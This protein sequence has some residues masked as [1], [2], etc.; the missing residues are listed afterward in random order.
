MLTAA[1]SSLPAEAASYAPAWVRRRL[2]EGVQA[3]A[4]G[5]H[6]ELTGAVLF[7]DV[8]GFTPLAE[9]SRLLNDYFGLLLAVVAEHGGEPFKFAGDALMALWPAAAADLATAT[10]RAAACALAIQTRLRHFETPGSATLSLRVAVGQGSGSGMQL[11]ANGRWF[12]VVGGP[13]LSDALRALS[14]AHAREAVVS[15]DA[16]NAISA[17]PANLKG[18]PPCSATTASSKPK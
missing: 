18:S 7:A 16:W 15:A 1:E 4:A 9:L 6:V 2:A 13:P 12:G 3:P 17:S 8:S 5:E 11:E 14:R 10:Q